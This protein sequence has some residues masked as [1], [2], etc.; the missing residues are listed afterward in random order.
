MLIAHSS[1]GLGALSHEEERFHFG[2]WSIMKSPLIM[3]A[4]ALTS[5]TSSQS[6]ATL[7]NA[8]VI[9][10]NQDSLGEQARLVRRYTEEEWDIFVGTLSGDR[11]VVGLANWKNGSTAASVDLASVLGIS[12]ATARDVWA[13][14][15]LGTI[16]GTYSKTLAPHQLQ[17]LVLSNV[18]KTSA[19]PKSTGY[20]TATDAT[21]S[22][23]AAKTTCSSTQ[24]LPA[25]AKVGF[26]GQGPAAA[27]VTFNGIKAATSGTK[28]LG[29]DFIN[30]DIATDSAW[31][32]GSNTR[33]MT[34]SVNGAT[35]KRWAFPISGGNWFDTGRLQIEVAGF[36]A[37]D[38]TV[39]FRAATDGQYA[40][41]LVGFE[42]FE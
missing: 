36:K 4:P 24:C 12:S 14:Q 11:L 33:N 6:L 42:V 29:V 16:S 41:D 10:L 15:D 38:N 18:A 23:S 30:Y 31:A 27:A 32:N 37:G 35:P 22:G 26:I 13:A 40:P 20:Y 2:L 3:G 25:H 28:L 5:A 1:V 7:G 8:E 19:T 17:L 39:V 21:L 9:A 34:I